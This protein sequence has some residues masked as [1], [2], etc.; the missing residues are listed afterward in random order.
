MIT[1]EPRLEGF[2][3]ISLAELNGRAALLDRQE[4]KYLIRSHQLDALGE[5]LAGG[6]DVLAIDGRSVFTYETIYFDTADFEAYH[7]HLQGRRRRYKIR[8]RYYVDSDLCY[9]E[10]KLKG[11]R[12]RT[13]KSRRQCPLNEHGRLSAQGED[14]VRQ[15]FMTEY[16]HS[17]DAAIFPR[18]AMIYRRVTLVGRRAPERVTIDY[19]F[20]F[21]G[22]LDAYAAAPS[23][24][25]VV[26]VKSERGRGA[27]DELFRRGGIRGG[28]CSKYCVGLNLVR[29]N[30]RHNPFK[31]TLSGHFDPRP[32]AGSAPNPGD[33]ESAA[34][35]TTGALRASRPTGTILG[36][37]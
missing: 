18:L 34:L 7:Q 28:A 32:G 29:D 30:L 11:A 25:I 24:V 27:A 16:G 21:A 19:G 17:F 2:G 22:A 20:Q 31:R 12:G 35:T 37:V 14:F 13:V 3:Q 1:Y 36:L 15:A 33:R 23:E 4:N 26:E 5:D 10:V 8:T 6:F 9:L